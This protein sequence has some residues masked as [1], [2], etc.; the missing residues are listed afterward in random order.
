MAE[1]SKTK[2]MSGC[3]GAGRGTLA[4][5]RGTRNNTPRAGDTVGVG[6]DEK[7]GKVGEQDGD[8]DEWH[9]HGFVLVARWVAVAIG[10]DL[11]SPLPRPGGTRLTLPIARAPKP[12]VAC[13]GASLPYRRRR[14]CA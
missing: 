13:S 1:S 4:R 14:P 3:P 12:R 9:A 10:V 11:V 5:G 7:P 8:D 2:V 6:P